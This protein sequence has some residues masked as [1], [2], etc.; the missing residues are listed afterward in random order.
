MS[1]KKQNAIDIAA[2]T[3]KLIKLIDESSKD[4]KGHEYGLILRSMGNNGLGREQTLSG[5]L[6]RYL[7]AQLRLVNKLST[8][9]STPKTMKG[10]AKSAK[11][12][13]SI[14]ALFPYIWSYK[15]Q[16]IQETT[17]DSKKRL[18]N[19]MSKS[20]IKFVCDAHKLDYQEH[21]GVHFK[22]PDMLK[23]IRIVSNRYLE[24]TEPNTTKQ[25]SPTGTIVWKKVTV[26]KAN[27]KTAA[28]K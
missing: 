17:E 27:A 5:V 23:I 16:T 22:K 25:L 18:L 7:N 4:I 11:K 6:L 1:N 10:F 19:N 9:G 8:V 28:A 14:D 15:L 2:K 26:I 24:L 21:K 3:E 13:K 12:A 20:I